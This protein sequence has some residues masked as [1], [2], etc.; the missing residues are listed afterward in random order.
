MVS[1]KR[2]KGKERKAKQVEKKAENERASV[3]TIWKGLVT[4]SDCNHG[5]GKI[6]PDDE[7]H[8]VSGFMDD[9][10]LYWLE[11]GMGAIDSLRDTYQKHLTVWRNVSYR[12]IAINILIC[13]GT[14]ML[15]EACISGVPE[16]R[17]GS[18]CSGIPQAVLVCLKIILA[19]ILDQQSTIAL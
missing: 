1:R 6:I 19:A 4:H 3:R 2:N 13:I 14:N 10:F 11:K 17:L 18:T 5:L 16:S 12:K 9:F 7:N 15:M 8:P